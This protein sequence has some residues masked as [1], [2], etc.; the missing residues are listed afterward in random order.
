MSKIDEN[1]IQNWIVDEGI[2]KQKMPDQDAQFHY[3]IEYPQGNIMDI[4]QPKGKDDFVLFVCGTQVSPEH[5]NL[6]KDASMKDR[7]K[8]L[9]ELRFELNRLEPDFQ[10]DVNN[11]LMLSQFVLQD[12][13]YEDGLTKNELMKT[14]KRIFKSKLACTMVIEKIFGSPDLSGGLNTGSDDNVMFM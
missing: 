3:V 5:V 6:M 9:F 8:F 12:A 11:E 14:I 13:L 2:F 4:I 10:L 1:I 7:E